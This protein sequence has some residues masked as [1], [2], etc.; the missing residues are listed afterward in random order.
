MKTC[1][2]FLQPVQGAR[3]LLQIL[4]HAYVV[5]K[6]EAD[7]VLKRPKLMACMIAT[8]QKSP[9]AKLY[10]KLS[11]AEVIDKELQVM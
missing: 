5:L 8:L 7:I 3:S 11:Y 10:H 4:L 9:N 6:V 1:S 2:H